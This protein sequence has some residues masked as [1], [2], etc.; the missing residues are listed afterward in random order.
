MWGLCRWRRRR[1]LRD[2]DM[3][4]EIASRWG[5]GTWDKGQEKMSR[6]NTLIP[7]R[8]R[9]GVPLIRR[10]IGRALDMGEPVI[11]WIIRICG[12]SAILF[13]MAI[14]VFVFVEGAPALTQISLKEFFF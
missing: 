11:E 6:A 12:W 10:G 13:V 5:H 8:R 7:W 4:Q 9:V 3:G 14:F 2:R 1:W